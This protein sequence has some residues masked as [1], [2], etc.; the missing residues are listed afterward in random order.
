[1]AYDRRKLECLWAQIARSAL[2]GTVVVPGLGSADC[3]DC[4]SHFLRFDSQPSFEGFCQVVEQAVQGPAEI[5][6][7]NLER[8]Q[9]AG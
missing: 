1:M 8:G 3:N 7:V 4:E 5:V 2:G 9:R 6:R